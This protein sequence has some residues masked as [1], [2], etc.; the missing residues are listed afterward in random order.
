MSWISWIVCPPDVV[1]NF[2]C[3]PDFL[4]NFM[5][6]SDVLQNFV[7]YPEVVNT[8]VSYPG[9]VSAI[10]TCTELCVLFKQCAASMYSNVCI[11]QLFTTSYRITWNVFK[12]EF[13]HVFEYFRTFIFG[14]LIF[15]IFSVHKIDALGV[16]QFLYPKID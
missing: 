11:P 9:I 4:H 3:Y 2:L 1:H 16:G 13:Q 10:Q 5:W 8:C 6:Y 15:K 7:C 12:L 14:T